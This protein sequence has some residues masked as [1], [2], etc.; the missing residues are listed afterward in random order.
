M[1][2]FVCICMHAQSLSCIEFP[3]TPWT[4]A[5][6]APL[7]MEFSWQE[8]WSWLPFPSPGDL[9]DLR[10]ESGL[11]HWWAASLPLSHQGNTH[12][13]THTHTHT[14]IYI[15]RERVYVYD[16]YM[17]LLLIRCIVIIRFL[18]VFITL[19]SPELVI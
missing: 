18:T 8:Y 4:V 15:D 14:Y 17:F 16:T 12:T 9:P 19:K 10:I 7:S 2:I 13:H 5:H 1:C 11:L 6:A 3:V